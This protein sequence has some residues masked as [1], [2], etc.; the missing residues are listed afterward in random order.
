[1]LSEEEINELAVAQFACKLCGARVG[2]WCVRR[3]VRSLDNTHDARRV[4]LALPNT[5]KPGSVQA[6]PTHFESNRRRH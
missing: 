4:K 6:I 2:E 1:M 5:D 3:G